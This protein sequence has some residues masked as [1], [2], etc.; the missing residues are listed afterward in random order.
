MKQ[1][2]K[3]SLFR[4]SLVVSLATFLSRIL[5]MARDVVFA[6]LFGAGGSMDAFFYA[7][8][9]PNFLRRLFAEGAFNQAFIPVLTEYKHA[10]G[11]ESVR[12]LITAVQLYLGGVVGAITILAIV[13]APLLA[14]VF[15]PG[16]Y[17]EPEKLD[18]VAGFLRI[19]F[20]YLFFISLT[21]LGSSV[22][23]SYGHF[24]APAMAPVLLNLSLIG[25]AYWLSPLFEVQQTGLAIGVL[26]AGMVQ[27]LFLWPALL[28]TGVWAPLSAY[29]PHPGVKK[30]MLLMVPGL[31]AVS[32]SQINLLFDSILASFLVDGSV[33]WLYYSDRLTEL[34]LGVFGIA[35]ATV[36]LPRLSALSAEKNAESFLQA[37]SWAIKLV[38][39]IGLPAA[40]ALVVLPDAL[41]TLLF[42]Y[43]D[44]T[45]Q[46][47]AQSAR[48]L[49]AY[50]LGLPA[51]MLI[52]VLAPAFFAHQDTKTPVKI[53]IQAMVWN[54]VFNAL[55]I[56]PLAHVGLALATSL[57]AWLNAGL[58]AWTLRS[59]GRLPQ[60][61]L[62]LKP[63]FI[64]VMGSAV[65]GGVLVWLQSALGPMPLGVLERIGHISTLVLSGVTIYALSLLMFGLKPRHFK[66]P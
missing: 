29:R 47:V 32:V 52:K 7:F 21:A 28:K 5:G 43:G 22:L 57:S 14:F 55:L 50:S 53:G 13:A 10:E 65:M 46:D 54:M 49:A 59:K 4:S 17:A 56:W 19:T 35:I 23:N 60:R 63:M 6:T 51:F 25:S 9:I 26:L 58:L 62:W 30:I 8:K 31:F 48:S 41:L 37:L 45:V 27:W 33:G 34:P 61:D 12:K 1:S 20:P 66:H 38:M 18:L 36:L 11:D 44:F 42:Q 64:I 24:A 16:F 3:K 40:I 39:L 15:A 2:G